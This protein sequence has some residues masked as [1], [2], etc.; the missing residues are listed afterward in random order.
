MAPN[1]NE[2]EV[3]G[4]VRGRHGDLLR[5][6]R[7]VVWWQQIRERKE[8]A[9]GETSERGRFRLR[10]LVPEDAAEPLLLVLEALSEH[11]DAPL[12]S[13]VTAAKPTLEINLSFE[14]PDQ[15]EWAT[16]VRSN[17]AVSRWPHARESG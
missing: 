14:A 8:L 6:A 9:A 2:Y 17:R 3:S 16:L 10:Y 11:L 12:Y 7:V 15:S 1:N 13:S 5:H 4:V